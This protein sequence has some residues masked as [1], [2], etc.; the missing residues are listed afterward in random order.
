MFKIILTFTLILAGCS[1]IPNPKSEEAR[2]I[3]ASKQA[4]YVDTQEKSPASITRVETTG[5]S[6]NYIF[7]VTVDSPDTGCDRYADWWEV[8]TPEGELIYRRVLLH[9][10][11]DEQPFERTGGAVAIKPEQEVIVRVHMSP[12]GYSNQARKGT[13]ASG[14]AAVT[15]A[16]DFAQDLAVVEPL[17]QNCAF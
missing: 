16:D 1:T 17:P 4:T 3:A 9:S 7:A 11:V 6:G 15:L 8:V 2:L 5:T 10:H 12:N 13:V 14:F